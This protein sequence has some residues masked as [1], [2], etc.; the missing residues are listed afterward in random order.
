VG[1]IAPVRDDGDE[2]ALVD[3]MLCQKELWK[4]KKE[5]E[6]TGAVHV[7]YVFFDVQN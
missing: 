3:V 1:V 6:K 2:M 7:T 5:E 4:E